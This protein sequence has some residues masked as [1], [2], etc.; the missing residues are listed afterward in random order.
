MFKY[1]TNGEYTNNIE[2]FAEIK[3]PDTIQ[4]NQKPNQQPNQQ[5]N[6]PNQL[7]I[8]QQ[9][10][11]QVIALFQQY[12]QYAAQ[13]S[14]IQFVEQM[15]QGKVQE[16]TKQATL[17]QQASQQAVLIQQGAQQALKQATQPAAK[18]TAI[19]IGEQASSLAVLLQK[20]AKKLTEEAT[21]GAAMVKFI[22]QAGQP[23]IQGGLQVNQQGAA[24]VKAIQQAGQPDNQ[25]GAAM[26]KAIQ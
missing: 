19:K 15:F 8:Q 2:Q 21:Q 24:M 17:L 12:V 26:V 10:N 9:L 23:D 22:Q 4:P 6:Q 1:F 7:I 20:E 5:P 18:L 11:D 13:Q 25:Q 16:L 3:K 14:N